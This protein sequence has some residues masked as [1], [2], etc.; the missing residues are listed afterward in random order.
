[1]ESSA[2]DS[3]LVKKTMKVFSYEV[4]QE[5]SDTLWEL[6]SETSFDNR[7][8]TIRKIKY[9]DYSSECKNKSYLFINKNEYIYNEKNRVIKMYFYSKGE[10]EP[11]LNGFITYKTDKNDSIVQKISEINSGAEGA[12]KIIDNIEYD[13][14]GNIVKYSKTSIK[15]TTDTIVSEIIISNLFDKR[16]NLIVSEGINQGS[17]FKELFEYDSLGNRISY[18]FIGQQ[19]DS[20]DL[21]NWTKKF[22][23][24]KL[25]ELTS[26]NAGNSCF[27]ESYYYDKSNKLYKNVKQYI[28]KESF[29]ENYCNSE[30]EII[31]TKL[32]DSE[33]KLSEIKKV[34]YEY[35]SK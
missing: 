2:H 30:G 1:M 16:N 25:I 26:C 11:Y 21:D 28:G 27:K 18:K 31:L 34:E 19:Y 23:Q 5:T 7:G 35:Y 29:E 32:Y 33:G 4:V 22:D 24:N 20:Y 17:K 6:L 13:H 12:M 10:V 3:L 15:I 9:C 14:N 8:N